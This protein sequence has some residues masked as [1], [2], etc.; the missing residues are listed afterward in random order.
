MP[1][2]REDWYFDV[3]FS[4][5]FY[6]DDSSPSCLRWKVDVKGGRL[7][8]MNLV[9]AGDVAGSES[10]RYWCTRLS[11]KHHSIH[12]IILSLFRIRV[13]AGYVVDHANGNSKD[14]RIDNLRV[15]KVKANARNT[16]MPCVNSSGRVGVAWHW[17]RKYPMRVY[18][19]AT[20]SDESNKAHAKFFSAR[21]FGIFP[22]WAMACRF[23][24]L[25][26]ASAK[27]SYSDRHGK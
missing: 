18:A 17:S 13:P 24:D 22:A 19:K 25:V 21:D 15:V 26:V 27:T 14:N 23:R 16:K 12:R 3:D 1:S 6:Y 10:D 8:G 7:H 20:W 2:V 4:D 5:K 9:S 11:K